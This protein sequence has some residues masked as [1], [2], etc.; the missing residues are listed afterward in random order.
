[1]QYDASSASKS[2]SNKLFVVHVIF[3]FLTTYFVSRAVVS[4]SSFF[5]VVVVVVIVVCDGKSP[6]IYREEMKNA[7]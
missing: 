2:F 4:S 5:A 3:T 7:P 6:Y 1:M